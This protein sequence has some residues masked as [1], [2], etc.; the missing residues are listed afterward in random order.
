LSGG[1][2]P[3]NH[4]E[5]KSAF[6]LKDV[7]DTVVKGIDVLEEFDDLRLEQEIAGW[8]RANRVAASELH[9]PDDARRR[10][11]DGQAVADLQVFETPELNLLHQVDETLMRLGQR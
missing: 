5:G 3:Q 1:V 10:S 8:L 7:D 6:D 4:P 11:H 2:L 9:L